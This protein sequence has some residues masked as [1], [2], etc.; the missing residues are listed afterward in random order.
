MIMSIFNIKIRIYKKNIKQKQK[1]GSD[2]KCFV[3]SCD[4]IVLRIAF[5]FSLRLLDQVCFAT[6]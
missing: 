6:V 2:K 5:S 3:L 4:E 1:K